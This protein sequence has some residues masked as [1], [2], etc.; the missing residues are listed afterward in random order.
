MQNSYTCISTNIMVYTSYAHT[1]QNS[2]DST[3]THQLPQQEASEIIRVPPASLRPRTFSEKFE[4][5]APRPHVCPRPHSQVYMANDIIKLPLSP[6]HKV[7]NE[8]RSHHPSEIMP[9]VARPRRRRPRQVSNTS[10]EEPVLLSPASS[11]TSEGVSE[12]PESPTILRYTNDLHKG[13]ELGIVGET[14]HAFDASG[15]VKQRDIA[16]H[17]TGSIQHSAPQKPVEGRHKA[18]QPLVHTQPKFPLTSVPERLSS[19]L[20][21][22]HMRNALKAH[23][24]SANLAKFAGDPELEKRLAQQHKKTVKNLSGTNIQTLEKQQTLKH[25][26][27]S[28]EVLDG[29]DPELAKWLAKQ[30]RKAEQN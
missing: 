3:S 27:G 1:S 19:N 28:T 6:V 10:T 14:E 25:K 21:H 20:P 2:T 18:Y 12:I 9:P 24:A 13:N 4:D 30:S 26:Q 7:N 8:N 22:R 15:R 23:E 29:I 16:Q 5:A 17:R 11:T